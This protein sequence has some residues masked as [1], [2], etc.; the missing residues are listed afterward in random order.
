VTWLYGPFQTSL[1]NEN[2]NSDS[3]ASLEYCSSS[4][5]PILKK[6]SLSQQMLQASLS[7]ASLRK[8]S[9]GQAK[10]LLPRR[11]SLSWNNSFASSKDSSLPYRMNQPRSSSGSS[12]PDQAS[13]AS[14]NVRF[15]EVVGQCIALPISGENEIIDHDL[16]ESDEDVVMMRRPAKPDVKKALPENKT[17][18][19]P[20]PQ[21]ISKLPDASLKCS[22][23]ENDAEKEEIGLGIWQ[24]PTV[25]TPGAPWR[26]EFSVEEEEVETDDEEEQWKPPKW[27][28]RRKDSVQIFQDKLKSIRMQCDAEDAKYSPPKRPALERRLEAGKEEIQVTKSPVIKDHESAVVFDLPPCRSQLESFSF[29]NN[30]KLRVDTP[31][32]E[33]LHLSPRS[34]DY[35]E[36]ERLIET[37][38]ENGDE[39]CAA[40]S[41]VLSLAKTAMVNRIMD[42]FWVV[43]N[44]MEIIAHHRDALLPDAVRKHLERL[45]CDWTDPNEKEIIED[46]LA[47]I[48]EC[49]D[50]L[51]PHQ[52]SQSDDQ[53]QDHHHH[54]PGSPRFSSDSGY[55]SEETDKVRVIIR[56]VNASLLEKEKG[57]QDWDLHPDAWDEDEAVAWERGY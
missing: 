7:S 48:H 45:V 43:Y 21:T 5:K 12:S 23:K 20:L 31:W 29:S 16:S 46:L 14:K 35:F 15:H 49:R 27:M 50:Q 13:W 6:L 11:N 26:D 18:E 22:E 53:D 42:E 55:G 56:D 2:S 33:R 25:L 39:A 40:V 34:Q 24:G 19:S 30:T 8:D 57:I 52:S 38:T 3:T 47:I 37:D 36:T 28:H 41:S 10:T 4:I 54:M 9:A 51:T 17:H 32:K 44:D 1:N